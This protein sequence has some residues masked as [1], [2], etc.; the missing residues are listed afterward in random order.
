MATNMTAEQ[1]GKRIGR[2]MAR[3][4][5]AEDMPREWTGLDAQD[6]DQIPG[7]IDF[8][9]VE[10]AAQKEYALIIRD[11]SKRCASL[12]ANGIEGCVL[13]SGHYDPHRSPWGEF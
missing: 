12:D 6:I 7:G 3:D 2:A 4:V 13:D 10:A 11:A 8:D 1:V 9:E 5:L